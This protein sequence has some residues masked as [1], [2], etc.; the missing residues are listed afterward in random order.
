MVWHMNIFIYFYFHRINPHFIP[1]NG[2]ANISTIFFFAGAFFSCIAL[3]S[4]CTKLS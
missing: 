2:K 1:E 4:I 3:S